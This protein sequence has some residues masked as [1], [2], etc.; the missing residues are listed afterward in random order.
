M[1][2]EPQTIDRVSFYL[3][4]VVDFASAHRVTL[5][6]A[7]VL[8]SDF[9][10]G[11]WTGTASEHL[12]QRIR[13]VVG[14][15]WRTLRLIRK[16]NRGE[17]VLPRTILAQ[18]DRDARSTLA[19]YRAQVEAQAREILALKSQVAE[20]E[21]IPHE[22]QPP[23]TTRSILEQQ[24]GEL[25]HM[26]GVLQKLADAAVLKDHPIDASK[27]QAMKD[28]IAKA[29]AARK[30]L[31]EAQA[32]MREAAGLPLEEK[33]DPPVASQPEASVA[34]PGSGFGGGEFGK[35]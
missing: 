10:F 3:A 31:D 16:A 30:M 14:L 33:P 29:E 12:P 23:S 34:V 22:S 7:G 1:F 21:A 32:E 19:G 8:V 28:A 27:T 4:S 15:I 26:R 2:V 11:R 17:P 24:A 35:G 20:H 6:V 18:V 9:F 25:A 13:Q 5:A